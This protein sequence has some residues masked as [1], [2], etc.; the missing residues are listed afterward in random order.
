MPTPDLAETIKA[1]SALIERFVALLHEEQ[2]ALSS[3]NIGELPT[4]S[5]KKETFATELNALSGLRN[6]Q[7]TALGFAE[8]RA[9]MDAWRAA[10]PEK[11]AIVG[12]WDKT[13]SLAAEARELNRVNGELI[14]LRMEHNSKALD[15]LVRSRDSL[16][17]YGPDG[18]STS[19]EK[20]GDRRINDAV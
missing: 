5:Q 9:G 15:I 19:P 2:E 18:L 13:L 7:L 3:G 17:L 20:D 11:K 6:E 1:E 4:L 8:G 10:N 16:A 12:A 14:R